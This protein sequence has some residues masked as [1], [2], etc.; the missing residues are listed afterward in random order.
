MLTLRYLW[1]KTG[2]NIIKK[3]RAKQKRAG[4]ET[5]PWN[6]FCDLRNLFKIR[7]PQSEI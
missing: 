1:K 3:K 5:P 4:E 6:H 2:R 7:N